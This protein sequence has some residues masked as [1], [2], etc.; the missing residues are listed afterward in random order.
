[1]FRKFFLCCAM[2]AFAK[3]EEDPLVTDI[4]WF[5]IK[6]DNVP[7]GRIQI[8][9]F[10]KI[11]PKT[12]KNFKQLAEE[13]V[14]KGF[15]ST[16]FHRVVKNFMIQGGDITRGDG[17]GGRSIYNGKFPDENFILE[18]Y[19]AGWVSMANAGKDT[20]LSQF[21]ISVRRTS[22]LNGKHVVFGKVIE[23]MDVVRE[24]ENLKTEKD[25]PTKDA[26]IADAG[27]IPLNEPFTES[28]DSS[29]C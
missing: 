14:G 19:E 17:T 25:K 6:I 11:V 23:G 3:C 10:G 8:G 27:T 16:K 22:E 21:F 1:M 12:V 24:I 13:P 29:F 18:H 2:I 4:V 26:V 9:L 5:D 7:V 20:N 15:K 28:R